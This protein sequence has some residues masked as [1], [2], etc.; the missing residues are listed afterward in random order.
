MVKTASLNKHSKQ[1]S[2]LQAAPTF[3]RPYTKLGYIFGCSNIKSMSMSNLAQIRRVSVLLSFVF[4]IPGWLAC[5]VL[6]LA[7]LPIDRVLM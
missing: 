3:R 6:I 2:K 7:F 4:S 1:E 5:F